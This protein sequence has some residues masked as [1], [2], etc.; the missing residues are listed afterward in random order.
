MD[1]SSRAVRLADSLWLLAWCVASSIWCVTAAA[2]LGATFDEPVYLL[3]GLE[4][5]RDG[6]P[7]PLMRLG[8]MPLPID[9]VTLPL[10][11]KERWTGQTVDPVRDWEQVLPWARGATLI[12]WWLLLIY[13]WRSAR[14]LAGPWAGRLVVPLLA[15]EPSLLANASLATTDIAITA[16]LLA[17]VYHFRAGRDCAWPRRRAL[18]AFWFGVALLAKASA[19]VYAPICLFLVGVEHQWRQTG[20]P[21]P[22]TPQLR[23]LI[24]CLWTWLRPLRRDTMVTLVCG[25]VLA[26]VYC[27]SDW[28]SQRSFLTWATNLPDGAGRSCLVWTAEHLRVFS[29]IGEG[30]VKQITHNVRGHGAYLAGY[31]DTRSLWFYF[32]VLLTIKLTLTLL[33]LPLVLAMVRPRVMLNWACVTA[34]VLLVWSLTFRVQIGIR[35]VLPLVVLASVGLAAGLV[36]AYQDSGA[37]RRR[38]LVGTAV[39]GVSWSLVSAVQV[40]PDGLCYVNEIWGGTES[41]YRQVSDANYDWGQGLKEPANWQERN[42]VIELNL[43]YFGTDPMLCRLPMRPLPFYAFTLE[44]PEDFAITVRGHYLAVST[45]L[46][47]G[48]MI[49]APVVRMM[50]QYLRARRPV[51]RTPTFFIYDFRQPEKEA[52]DGRQD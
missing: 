24:R 30:I 31:S 36:L 50:A 48:G 23:S 13:A 27:G 43:C 28:E 5:W 22:E 35:L 6:K 32:P 44:K 42:Q 45:T 49:D 34:A 12:F 8:T 7:G 40:W 11:L 41:G 29:N 20:L 52:P 19:I 3:R 14:L 26:T 21:H 2:Q 51:A 25:F 18:P 46:V 47:Y 10:Y 15:C 33:L 9:V 1:Q 37:W 4:H 38:L 39:A 17:L 16:C